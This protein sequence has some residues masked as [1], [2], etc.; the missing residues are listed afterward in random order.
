MH[1]GRRSWS[2]G[3]L[4]AEGEAAARWLRAAGTRVLAT[5]MDNSPAFVALDE[6]AGDTDRVHVPLPL[7]FT[8]AQMRHAV[9]SAGVDTLL[10]DPPLAEL[11][12]ALRWASVTVAGRALR[13][14]RCESAPVPLPPGTAKITFTSGTTGAPK[15]VCLGGPALQRVSESLVATLA[16]LTIERHLNAL[17]FAVL[18]ENVA[19]LMAPRRQGALLQTLPL[20]ELGLHGSSSFDAARFHAAL[21]ARQPHSVILLP[22]M[23]RAWCGFLMQTGQ[24]A[25]ASLKIVAVGGAAVG[26]PLIA[27]A[28]ALGIP[29]NEGYGLSEGCS[30][31]TLNLPWSQRAGSV[32]RVLPHARLR[33]APDGELEIAGSLFSGYLGDSAPVPAWWPTGDLGSIDDEG[34]VHVQGRKKNVLITAYGRNVSPEWIETA[35]RSHPAVLQSVVLGDGAPALTAVLWPMSSAI[36]DDALEAAVAAANVGL[37]DYARIG[38]WTRARAAFDPSTGLA[39]DNGR[40]QREAVARMHADALGLHPAFT[41]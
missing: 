29:A 15:G 34:F 31:Q 18:L 21:Q 11:W 6:A 25:P 13:W 37:P 33:V 14:A 27:A 5:A 10:V 2:E 16:P 12:P 17:P 36:G 22:Q 23:L 32:G 26:A 3:Q 1:D 20:A 38:R 39:T 30:V 4:A 24:R 40:A 7:F 35:L 9:A 8:P 28:Q 41:P 19:G